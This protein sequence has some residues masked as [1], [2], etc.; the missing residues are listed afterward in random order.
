MKYLLPC[1]KCGEKTPIDVNQ[2]GQQIACQCGQM[3]EIPSLRG[4]RELD[5]LEVLDDAG[6]AAPRTSWNPG[7]G[8]VFVGGLVVCLFGLAVL[9]LAGLNWKHIIVPDRP[10]TNFERIGVEIDAMTPAQAWDE[11]GRLRTDG[12][13]RYRPPIHVLAQDAVDFWRTVMVVAACVAV[14][15]ILASVGAC[16]LPG[17]RR[18]G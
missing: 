1:E 8:I 10:T 14:A 7:R 6:T 17:A 13:G 18:D 16:F 5:V 2:A 9:S 3:L 12:I 15:G 11:W 4:I